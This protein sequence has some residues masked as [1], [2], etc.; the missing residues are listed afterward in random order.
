MDKKGRVCRED[1]EVLGIVN[2]VRGL[3]G[4][5]KCGSWSKLRVLWGTPVR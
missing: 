2:D 1:E 4:T 5:V 3:L